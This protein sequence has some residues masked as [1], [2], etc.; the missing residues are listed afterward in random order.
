MSKEA[1]PDLDFPDEAPPGAGRRWRRYVRPGLIAVV[2]LL[3]LWYPGGMLWVQAIDDN[4]D[5][6]LSADD[7]PAGGSRTVA[8]MAALIER[9]VNRHRWVA[10]DPFFLPGAALDNMP[11]FQQGI[12]AALG[13]VAFEMTDQLGRTRG[14]SRADPDLQEAA[15]LL[16]YPGNRW[17][18]NFSVTQLVTATSASQ[19]RQARKALLA[20]NRRLAD[21]QAA[22]ERRSDNLQATLDRIAADLGSSSA[23]IDTHV[24]VNSHQWI[25]WHADDVFYSVKGQA[26]AYYLVLRELGIDYAAVLK[27]RQLDDTW[28]QML[29]SLRLAATLR[30]WVVTNGVP[31]GAFLPNHLAAEGFYLLRARTQLREASGILQK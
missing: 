22:F 10:S 16:Q 2:V 3:L 25:D 14:S 13:R 6:A 5:F 21:N 8:M 7:V 15:G 11:N 24:S 20:Y 31:D 17:V 26:Y 18:L 1:E 4:P 23:L 30:P 27:E 28:K 9:E 19:Y 12:M 29:E